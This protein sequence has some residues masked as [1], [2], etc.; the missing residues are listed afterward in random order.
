M[1]ILGNERFAISMLLMGIK[2]SYIIRTKDDGIK[3]LK[4]I[5]KEDIVIANA[6]IVN[7]VPGLDELNNLV[8]VPDDSRNFATIDDLKQLIKSAV[9]IEIQI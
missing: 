4:K 5:D 9:G 6:S 7:M 3:I 1:I 8:T 2:D